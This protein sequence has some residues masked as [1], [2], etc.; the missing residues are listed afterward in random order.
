MHIEIL[1]SIVMQL[2]NVIEA[3]QRIFGISFQL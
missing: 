1:L 2:L 3:I